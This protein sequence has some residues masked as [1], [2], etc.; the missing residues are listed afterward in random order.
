MCDIG[1]QAV[2]LRFVG[3]ARRLKIAKTNAKISFLQS[4]KG[5]QY[6]EVGPLTSMNYWI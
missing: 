3:R 4:S 5:H 6:I 1:S 2:C